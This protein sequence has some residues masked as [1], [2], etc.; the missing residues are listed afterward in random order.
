MHTHSLVYLLRRISPF[1]I[2]KIVLTA[3]YLAWMEYGWTTKALQLGVVSLSWR[4]DS[5]QQIRCKETQI[6]VWWLCTLS[7]KETKTCDT[8][9]FIS[10]TCGEYCKIWFGLKKIIFLVIFININILFK[11]INMNCDWKKIWIL[12]WI[13]FM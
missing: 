6:T 10:Y 2:H 13:D 1:Q 8:F 11:Y 12:L 4:E 9:Y 7:N 5:D 3:D